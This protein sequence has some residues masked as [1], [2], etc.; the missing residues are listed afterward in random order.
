MRALRPFAALVLGALAVLLA[1]ASVVGTW[2]RDQVLDTGSYLTAVTPLASEPAVRAEVARLVTAAVTG[3]VEQ[4]LEGRVPDTVLDAARTQVR[5]G[6]TE[7][8]ASPAFRRLWVRLNRAGHTQVVRILRDD[9]RP[10]RG[11]VVEGGRLRLDLSVAVEEVRDGLAASGLALPGRLPPVDLVVDVADVSG[12]ER[13]RGPVL[14]LERAAGAGPW[15]AAACAVLAVAV[16]RRRARAVV[17]LATATG[18]AMA[19]LALVPALAADRLA[20]SVT[21]AGVSTT[22]ARAVVETIASPLTTTA[23]LATLG[24]AGA[25]VAGLVV[26]AFARR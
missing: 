16:A 11:V 4:R 7:F 8:T 5:T 3:A 17:L 9:P 24:A 6:A 13:A 14:L 2:A 23:V 15:A 12:V 21:G 26:G 25:A 22:A 20:G 18:L 1:V 19:G 10:V